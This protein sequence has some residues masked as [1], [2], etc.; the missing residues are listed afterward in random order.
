M[1]E[2]KADTGT[3]AFKASDLLLTASWI[4]NNLDRGFFP[5][6]GTRLTVSAKATVPVLDNKYYKLTVE[7]SHYTP[8][9]QD[10]R[11]VLL[12]RGR[13]G[14]GDGFGGKEMP[15]YDNFYAG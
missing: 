2:P 3:A 1:G 9:D 15:F 14:Y 8:L 5:T 10:R 13:M 6:Q 7:G 12:A 11:W 4:Y